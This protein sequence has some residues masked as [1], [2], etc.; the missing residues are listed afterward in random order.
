MGRGPPAP[1]LGVH[2]NLVFLLLHHFSDDFC[3]NVLMSQ[4]WPQ[5]VIVPRDCTYYDIMRHIVISDVNYPT[6]FRPT[7]VTYI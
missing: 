1:T 5:N 3:V 7:Y 2:L 4:K 6:H